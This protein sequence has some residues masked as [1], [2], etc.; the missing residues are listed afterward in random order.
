M[1]IVITLSSDLPHSTDKLLLVIAALLTT[2][3]MAVTLW[4]G[5]PINR[6]LGT[7]GI[8]GAHRRLGRYQFHCDGT[9]ESVSR[10]AAIGFVQSTRRP[11]D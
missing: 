4:L 9:E 10:S 11:I 1:R 7:T 8:N 6:L 5:R 3:L 2:A